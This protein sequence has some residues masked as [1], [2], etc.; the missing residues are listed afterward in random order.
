M[1]LSLA[2][3]LL[4]LA[5]RYAK[6]SKWREFYPTILYMVMLNLLYSYIVKTTPLWLYKSSLVPQGLL[7]IIVIYIVE[8]SMT[9]LFLSYHPLRWRHI[10]LYW[11]AWI[12]VFSAIEYIFFLTDRMDYFNGWNMYWSVIFYIIMFPML[13][14]H[15]KKP[16]VALMLSILF[17]LGF[18]WIFDYL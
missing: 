14:L 13:F 9:I 18:M 12:I 8:P 7:D 11:A 15:Y 2:G 3:I 4:F 6:W 10:S 17:T 16:P 5:L 1:T